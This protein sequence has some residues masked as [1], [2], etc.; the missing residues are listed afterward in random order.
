MTTQHQIP[1]D[2]QP[3]FFHTNMAP[4]KP[5]R[6]YQRIALIAFA[7]IA[8]IS[9]AL[10]IMSFVKMNALRDQLAAQA[11]KAAQD[12]AEKSRL[13]AE[14][15]Q[16]DLARVEALQ[17]QVAAEQPRQ[18]LVAQIAI[19]VPTDKAE[20]PA[21]ESDDSDV[22]EYTIPEGKDLPRGLIGVCGVKGAKAQSAFMKTVFGLNF[23]KKAKLTNE[24]LYK[25]EN[26]VPGKVWKLPGAQCPALAESSAQP[27]P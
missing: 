4:L 13:Q 8:I 25:L 26:L 10:T 12:K 5:R 23:N 9:L 1:A 18:K 2:D 6:N 22:I 24:D 16:A 14:K 20:A 11:V 17:K 27:T 15:V 21:P 19:K 3:L 7:A